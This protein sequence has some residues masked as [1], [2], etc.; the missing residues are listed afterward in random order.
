MKLVITIPAFNEEPTIGGVIRE[1]PRQISGIDVVEVLVLDDGSRDRTIEVAKAAGADVVISHPANKGLSATFQDAMNAALARG[2]DIVVNTDADN[3]YDQSRIGELVRPILEGRADV[4][5]GGRVVEQLE[6]MPWA[7]KYGNLLGSR[8]VSRLA[9]LDT[10]VDASTGFRAYTRE[11]VLRMHVFSQHTYTH[12]TL[13]QAVDQGMTIV[14]VPIKARAVSRKSRLIKSVPKHIARS[15]VVIVRIFTLYKPLRVFGTIGTIF[16]TVG[17][18][19]VGRFL[20][21]Y[22]FTPT[23]GAGHIQSLVLASALLIVGFQIFLIGLLASAVGWNRK[24]LEEILY[25]NRKRDAQK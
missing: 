13:I 3:H 22:W 2:A 15:L 16:V 17:L 5:I 1:I 9:G 20:Y 21:F 6:H 4:V 11:A 18:I 23:H 14:Q 25:R 24:I 12:E 10:T 8:L 7:N 19:A